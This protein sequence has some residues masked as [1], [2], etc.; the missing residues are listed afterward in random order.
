[1]PPHERAH[2]QTRQPVHDDHLRPRSP[3][4]A[5]REDPA[6]A[7]DKLA[8]AIAE[9]KRAEQ[10]S[11]PVDSFAA[12]WSQD[13]PRRKDST[14]LHNAERVSKFARDFAGV[15]LCDVTRQDARAW[16]LANRGRW[17]S[18]RAMYSDAVR[19]GLADSNP[20][21][22]LRLQSNTRGRRDS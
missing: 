15:L 2:P 18:V 9:R 3:H 21:E 11:E 12:R 1:V 16:A 14:N 20:F 5:V 17:K 4:L 6:R 13:Y 22:D 19:D 10:T 7:R 8:A